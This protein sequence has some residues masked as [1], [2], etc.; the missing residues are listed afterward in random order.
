MSD[1]LKPCPFCGGEAEWKSGGP[2]CAWVSCKKC[3]AETGDGSIPRIIA[4]WNRRADTAEVI[5]LRAR[6]A[7]LTDALRISEVGGVQ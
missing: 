4:A 7:A 2:G 3:P 1:D 5:A 6:V